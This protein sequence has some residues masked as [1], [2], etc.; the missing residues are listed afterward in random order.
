M[1]RPIYLL[2]HLTEQQLEAILHTGSP[3]LIIAGPGSGKTEV[4]TWRV[5]HLIRAGYAAPAHCLVTTFTNKAALEL[6]DRI[7]HNLHQA[8]FEGV[9]A[10]VEQMQ[11]CTIHS[12]CA[13]ILRQY[14]SRSS[15]PRGFRILDESGQFLFVYTH[16]KALGLDA[17]VKGRPHDFFSDVLHMFNLATEELVA[18]GDLLGWCRE[19]QQAAEERAAEAAGGK[20][21][22]KA[23]KAAD[24]VELWREEAIVTEGYRA[25]CDL[26]RERGLVDFAFLQ[27]HTLDLLQ[28]K[29][30]VVTELRE[31]YREIFVDEYQ[32]TNAAQEHILKYLA[33]AGERLTVVGD[34]DQS[35]YRFRGATVSN[36]LSFADRYAG[37]HVVKLTQ[38]FRSREPIVQHSLGVIVN[39]PARFPKD[40]FTMRGSGSDVLLVYE[41][42]VSEEAAAIAALLGRL[43]RSGKIRRWGDVAFLLRSVKSYAGDYVAALQA[44]SIPAYVMGDAT[45]FER[46]D[47][48]QL[49]CLFNFL[50]AT[51][52]WGDVHVRC[53]LMGL[54]DPT[55]MALQVYKGS[56]LDIADDEGLQQIGVQDANDRRRILDLLAL[57]RRV[58]A[59][60][61]T[62]L[63][64]VFYDLLAA[65]GHV[66]LCER[67]KC[68]EPLMNLGVMSRL[69]AAF[70]EH[71]GTRNFYPFQDYLR[72]MKEGGVNPAVV[73]PDNAVQVM[74]IHQAKGLEFPVV[75]I[76]SVM[77]GRLPGTYRKDR[78]EVPHKLRASGQ[79]E[80]PDPHLVDE[81]KLFYVAATRARELL[82]LGTADVVNKRGG[83]PS[84]F[85]VEMFGQ[86]LHGVADLSQARI[87]E[88]A[89]RAETGT[90]PRERLSFSQLAYFLQCPVRFKFAVAYGLEVPRP[91]PV[92]YG[93]NVHRALL[94]IHELARI[95]QTPSQG[96]VGEIVEQTWITALQ[97]N[98]AQDRQARQAAIKQLERYVTNHAGTFDRVK[99]AEVSFS[100]GLDRHVL[101]GKI[102]LVRQAGG[103]NEI[104]DFKTGKSVP[105]ALEQVD[106]QLD[107]YALGAEGSLGLRVARQ[108]VHFLEDDKVYAWDWSTQKALAARECLDAML[109]CILRQDL[110]P[111][112]EYCPRCSEF[113]SICPY[114]GG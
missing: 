80:V 45:F 86:D 29:P 48:Q 110:T 21:K 39:N 59:K 79:P 7:Q 30:D 31:R 28:S 109:D 2:A 87:E 40:L 32:D 27:C 11:V 19:Q 82:I 12:L 99:Q 9:E 13:D 66:R 20:S 102:D 83:G 64:E 95:G 85:L 18:S 44:E 108:A 113:R 81:R 56:L 77:T 14:Q 4:V 107:L 62:S 114:A 42:T 36:L 93:A 24:E 17:L 60:Q 74:T 76:G 33:A 106:T 6:K 67:A 52:P 50:G 88:A 25:Y 105:A 35:I 5:A 10:D 104:V 92:D 90:V 71:G 91:D 58:Q 78:Y 63:L 16:R 65:T 54:D 97:A 84:P 49:Y 8:G 26:L 111:R 47:I 46:E 3:L 53:P 75:V 61:H 100:L 23:R 112:L 15:L 69:V 89:S 43:H 37:A 22:A 72:L 68:T 51:K 1:G 38:N 98:P 94:V 103:E 57:K 55:C 73:A 34:D 41:R 70:D 101:V 96:D